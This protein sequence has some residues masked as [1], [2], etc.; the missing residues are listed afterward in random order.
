[1]G[2]SSPWRGAVAVALGIVMLLTS[3]PEAEFPWLSRDRIL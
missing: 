2:E 1:M 3:F